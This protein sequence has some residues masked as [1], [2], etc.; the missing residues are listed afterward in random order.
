MKSLKRSIMKHSFLLVFTLCLAFIVVGCA[1]K[2]Q[3]SLGGPTSEAETISPSVAWDKIG[4][5]AVI[6][7][8]RTPKEFLSGSLPEAVNIP[9][10]EIQANHALLDSH[11]D[12]EIVLY[13]GSGRR[14]GLAGKELKALGYKN[15]YNAGGFE[16]LAAAES[17]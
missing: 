2:R 12:Q 10:D 8:V 13:C 7:D 14:A 3:A 6:I 5:G 4:A 16:A 17:R 1:S 15:V 11:F 9:H